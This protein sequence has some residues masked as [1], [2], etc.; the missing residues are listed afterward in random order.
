MVWFVYIARARTGRYYVGIT[1]NA[2]ERIK[3][4][5]LGKGSQMARLQGPFMLVYASEVFVSQSLAR[6]REIQLKGWS[7]QKKERLING[8]WK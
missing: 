2:K 6:K 5:N 1:T 3:Q 8:E 4:H 7:R